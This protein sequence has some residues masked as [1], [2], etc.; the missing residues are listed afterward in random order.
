MSLRGWSLTGFL[1]C[2]TLSAV[3][4]RGDSSYAAVELGGSAGGNEQFSIEFDRLGVVN[5]VVTFNDVPDVG[6]LTVSFGTR[7]VGQTFGAMHNS[8][9]DT[10]PTA[11]LRLDPT[12]VVKTMFDVS[13]G[14]AI[15]LGGVQGHAMYTTPL[16][17]LFSS[18][19]NY[20]AFDLGHLDRHTS[21]LI[22]AFDEAGNGLGVFGNLPAGHNTF[23]LVESQGENLIAGISIYVPSKGMDWEGFGLNKIRFAFEEG[24]D[25]G[26]EIPEPSAL[27]VWSL[28]AGGGL[29]IA[30]YR[31]R[32]ESSP[33][34]GSGN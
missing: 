23:S 3:A 25:G 7:F 13:S 4:L 9:D 34:A 28:L 31:A 8:L 32:R 11:P 6:S 17:I 12:G 30:G 16:A 10:T 22:Q 21:T 24:P 18:G 14:A 26:G 19:V 33:A 27:V 1:L 5:P 15:A 2:A 29:A 20:V